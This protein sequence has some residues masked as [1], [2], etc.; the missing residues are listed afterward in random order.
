MTLSHTNEFFITLPSNS[1]LTYFPNNDPSEYKTKLAQS[2]SLLGKW[3]VA[4]AEIQYCRSWNN[5]IN[6]MVFYY[7]TIANP[8]NLVIPA[9][10]Y[11]TANDI[12]KIVRDNMDDTVKEKI[13][14][15]YYHHTGKFRF[16][17]AD[18]MEIVWMDKNLCKVFGMKPHVM[19]GPGYF[20][21]DHPVPFVIP[22]PDLF[23]YTDVA[24]S[25]LVGD[26][27]VPLLRIVTPS[28]EPGN[29]VTVSYDKLHYVPLRMFHFDTIEVNISGD[30]GNLIHFQFGRTIVKL[31]F[32]PR[33]LSHL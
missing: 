12:L 33:K 14:I 31:H 6:D 7:G 9:G 28:G 13:K 19:K 1:S 20:K 3:E 8:Y 18:K 2:I 5:V 10:H 32:R 15:K 11:E 21:S 25:V 29:R 23:V 4:L 24:S 27:F 26:S 22:E 17:L 16:S 30:G